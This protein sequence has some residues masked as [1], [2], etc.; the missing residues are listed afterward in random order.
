[1]P[2]ATID[3]RSYRPGTYTLEARLDGFKSFAGNIVLRQGENKIEKVRLSLEKVVQKIEVRDKEAGVST[4]SADSTAT[5]SSSQFTALPLVEQKFK[6]AL[7]LVPGVVRTMDGKLNFKGAPENQGMLLVDSAQTVDP[8]TGS[9]SIP[10]PLDAI[11]TLT[12][13]KAPYSAEYGGFS[14]GLTAIETKPPGGNWNFGLMDFIPGMRGKE[15]HLAGTSGFS[16]RL[17][18]S[19]PLIKNKINFSEALT[20]DVNKS[21]VRGLSW[22]H[23]E[24]KREGFNT[25]TTF[26]AVLS[27]EHL[28][29]VTLNGFSNHR[30]F[31]DINA[32]VPET[33]SADDEERG[34]SIGAN[35]SLQFNSGALL[36][37]I[38]RYTRFDSNAHGQGP[39]DM[40]I[41]PEGWGGNFFDSWKR[42][43]N[44]FQLLP[45]YQSPLKEWWGHH[46]FR[47]G[48]D[49]SY[50]S[51]DG[52]DRSHPIKLL[53]QDG[54]LAEQIVF[55]G[56][57]LLRAHDT[58]FAGFVQDHW[59]LNDRLALDIGGR[60]SSQS[61]GRSA[62]FAPRAGLVYSPFGDRK[63]II[64]AGGGSFS[65][66]SRC[67]RQAFWTTPRGLRASTASPELW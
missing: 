67:W 25:L 28:L 39:E 15:G 16:P 4:E 60:L 47:A 42:F 46:Q 19:G 50:R 61:I 44:Q 13:D 12:V 8:V 36:S 65:T 17:F 54:S 49:L 3:L 64:R 1:M 20:Y 29:S 41:T 9:F 26:Q 62:A 24:T 31:A 34:T 45:L 14:G 38:L 66:A 48:L 35:D 57:G 27:P 43:S 52:A 59:L 56:D 18:V 2:K 11:Q 10:I 40:L 7:P 23:D 33:A 5:I 6:A 51:F 32:L 55:Q 22:P 58:E 37:T 21:A 63:T 53:R 30:Q